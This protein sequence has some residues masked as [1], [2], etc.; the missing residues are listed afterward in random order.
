MRLFCGIR[1]SGY[2]SARCSTVAKPSIHCSSSWLWSRLLTLF[3]FGLFHCQQSGSFA[4]SSKG[5]EVSIPQPSAHAGCQEVSGEQCP[6]EGWPFKMQCRCV[7]TFEEQSGRYEGLCLHGLDVLCEIFKRI[8]GKM[9]LHHTCVPG[10]FTIFWVKIYL[11][12]VMSC[13]WK[14][15]CATF[16]ARKARWLLDRQSQALDQHLRAGCLSRLAQELGRWS[17]TGGSCCYCWRSTRWW[18]EP[19]RDHEGV[20]GG[21]LLQWAPW[22]KARRYL[23]PDSI[24]GKRFS[25][26]W[27]VQKRFAQQ[28]GSV[29][30]GQMM[31]LA[32]FWKKLSV[33]ALFFTIQP[34]SI[35]WQC[36]KPEKTLKRT[37][38]GHCRSVTSNAHS[39]LVGFF[40]APGT[41]NELIKNDKTY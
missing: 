34:N 13:F 7:G 18:D 2:S 10:T 31:A 8:G 15:Q 33:S 16:K 1:S 35:H 39:S 20:G 32:K 36:Q 25:A 21:P 26:Q 14:T 41:I 30:L 40:R 37:R 19:E 4:E 28:Q 3:F 5:G 27:I 17:F 24:Q 29:D 38:F 22:I 6:T 12:Q 11:L 9:S 23:G